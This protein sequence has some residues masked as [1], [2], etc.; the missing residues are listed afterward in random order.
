M[1]R[2][3]KATGPARPD[4]RV[5]RRAQTML[6]GVRVTMSR[7]LRPVT[8][9]VALPEEVL[10]ISAEGIWHGSHSFMTSLSLHL[11]K[12]PRTTHEVLDL[13]SAVSG[14]NCK[15]W[16]SPSRTFR[17]RSQLGGDCRKLTGLNGHLSTRA[18]QAYPLA[19][20][21]MHRVMTCVCN[22]FPRLGPELHQQLCFGTSRPP[23]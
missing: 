4:R 6:K 20:R 3:T 5:L 18:M 9:P 16:S 8:E 1:Y 17:T 21:S 14:I 12:S 23:R 11:T 19:A 13:V 2:Q 15:L 22:G 10:D 7:G